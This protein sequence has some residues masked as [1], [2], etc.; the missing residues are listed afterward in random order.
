MNPS[1]RLG[2]R[3]N[4]ILELVAQV[5]QQKAYSCAWDCCCDHGYLGIKILTENLCERMVFVDQVPHIIEQLAKK[6]EPFCTGK[7]KLIS[8]D[9]GQL[10]FNLDQLHLVILAGVGGERT[11]QIISA[12]KR[13][14]PNARIDYI[15]CPSTSRGVL[16]KYLLE[17]GLSI[18]FE[19]SVCENRR[20]YEIMFVEDKV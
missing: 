19:S 17:K 15:F 10:N 1:S 3:L 9:V 16:R 6:L 14:N 11:V 4:A 5:Q 7:H 2:P 8:A 13:N 18:K 20:F 12:I